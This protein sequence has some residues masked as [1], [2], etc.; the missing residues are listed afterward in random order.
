VRDPAVLWLGWAV[1]VGALLLYVLWSKRRVPAHAKT[2]WFVEIGGFLLAL[3]GAA[4][5]FAGGPIRL[6][7]ALGMTGFFIGFVGLF[8]FTR[9]PNE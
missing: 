6:G 9:E 7:A 5:A 8:L 4:I 2:G 3:I 1:L